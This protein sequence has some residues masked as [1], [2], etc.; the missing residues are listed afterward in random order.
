MRVDEEDGWRMMGEGWMCG[1]RRN[2]G[3]PRLCDKVTT[4]YNASIMLQPQPCLQ[5]AS[6][7]PLP[8][9]LLL[10]LLLQG[11]FPVIGAQK[12]VNPWAA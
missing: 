4:L 1:S 5:V 12:F 3:K 6:L 9:L 11:G 2:L 7:L 8:H 10:C